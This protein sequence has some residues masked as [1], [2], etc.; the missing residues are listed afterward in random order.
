M[1]RASLRPIHSVRRSSQPWFLRA[2][3][4][5]GLWQRARFHRADQAYANAI[6]RA[7][8]R[9]HQPRH[10][11]QNR[12]RVRVLCTGGPSGSEPCIPAAESEAGRRVP[13]RRIRSKSPEFFHSS[14]GNFWCHSAP[15]AVSIG[16][17]AVRASQDGALEPSGTP[18][19]EAHGLRCG[20]TSRERDRENRRSTASAQRAPVARPRRC[21][22]RGGNVEKTVTAR[23]VASAGLLVRLDRHDR[24]TAC[25]TRL[26]E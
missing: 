12:R 14:D 11:F 23:R 2:F 21:A 19:G 16:D 4:E 15:R 3:Q 20:P 13:R 22:P 26:E 6:P 5:L 17:H 25:P 1:S 18:L 8:A 10:G 9:R 7:G 24:P